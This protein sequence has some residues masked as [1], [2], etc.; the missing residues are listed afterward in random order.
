MSTTSKIKKSNV[1]VWVYVCVGVYVCVRVYICVYMYV[2]MY[3]CVWVYVCVYMYTW[4]C[5]CM[6]EC[7]LC[8]CTCVWVC[9]CMYMCASMCVH[10]LGMW[11]WSRK[12]CSGW[13]PWEGSIELRPQVT[14]S[15][16]VTVWWKSTDYSSSQQT[17]QRRSNRWVTS[18]RFF[19]FPGWQSCVWSCRGLDW[20]AVVSSQGG[21]YIGLLS[22]G[23]KEVMRSCPVLSVTCVTWWRL[24]G[25]GRVSSCALQS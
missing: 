23:N 7:V 14:Q 19:L 13:T 11:E 8:E 5:I 2:W 16:L 21:R 9:E 20:K 22:E 4:V 1:C 25:Q 3:M 6:C 10:V 15:E 17:P 12:R 24:G 18:G